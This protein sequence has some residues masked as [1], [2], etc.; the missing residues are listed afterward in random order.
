MTDLLSEPLKREMSQALHNLEVARQ[1]IEQMK[2][3]GIECSEQDAR[4]EHLK[5]TL[6]QHQQV[7]G[8]PK[9]RKDS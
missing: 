3:A 2:S 4:C 1:Y 7:F 5:Q 9:G 6:L 8:R